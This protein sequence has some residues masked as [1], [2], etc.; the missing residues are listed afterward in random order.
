MTKPPPY[1]SKPQLFPL[2]AKYAYM[3]E[4]GS[5]V[6]MTVA[7]ILEQEYPAWAVTFRHFNRPHLRA[8]DACVCD[9]IDD[10]DAW[11]VTE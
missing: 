10:F 9:W 4:D 6:K 2:H 1:D 3:E 11:E 7:E 5:I 8:L